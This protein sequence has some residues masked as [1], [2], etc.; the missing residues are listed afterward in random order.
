MPNGITLNTGRPEKWVCPDCG[1]EYYKKP[2]DGKCKGVC[3]G[4]LRRV[5]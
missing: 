2:S 4:K 1:V 5:F 3:K